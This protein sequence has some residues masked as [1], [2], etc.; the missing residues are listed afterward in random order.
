MGYLPEEGAV[1]YAADQ[2]DDW[3]E[4]GRI[5]DEVTAGF[6]KGGSNINLQREG[7][8]QTWFQIDTM[9]YKD[10]LYIM[11]SSDGDVEN[12][13]FG[14]TLSDGRPLPDWLKPTRQGLVIGRPPAGLPFIDLQIHGNSPDGAIS[15]TIRIDLHTG[16]ILD[17]IRDQRTDIGPGLFSDHLLAAANGQGED[18]SML[19]DAL[20]RWSEQP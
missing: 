16:A 18:I 12:A 15:D 6:F 14:I 11:P 5:I 20:R 9:V 10:Y 8:D 17:H 3:V 7:A 4:S 13:T 1:I 2:I 19:G